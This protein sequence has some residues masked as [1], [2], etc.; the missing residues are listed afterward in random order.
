MIDYV[1]L[2]GNITHKN[3]TLGNKE[4]TDSYL[5]SGARW[6][7]CKC[8]LIL[9]FFFSEVLFSDRALII[10]FLN[11]GRFTFRRKCPP[12]GYPFDF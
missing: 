5:V 1:D 3:G 2:V 9:S 10:M 7:V 6:C 12:R 8:V 11:N 4:S